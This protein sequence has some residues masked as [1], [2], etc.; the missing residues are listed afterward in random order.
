MKKHPFGRRA[1]ALAL[2]FAL[3]AGQ[4]SAVYADDKKDDLQ[5]ALLELL[6]EGPEWQ[7]KRFIGEKGLDDEWK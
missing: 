3:L 2:A 6:F 5:Q 7:Y 1:A 4:A